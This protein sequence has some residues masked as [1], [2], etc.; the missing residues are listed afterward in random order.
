MATDQ[1]I[2]PKTRDFVDDDEG[3]WEEVEDSTTAVLVQLDSR[4]GAWWGDPRAGSRNAEILESEVPT[5]GALQDSSRRALQAMAGAGIISNVS[6]AITD[7][8]TANGIAALEV[9]WRDRSTNRP[10]DLAYSPLG[11][12]PQIP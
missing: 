3:G 4:E 11:G 5:I 10:A 7:E 6:V 2:D 12:A 9:R 8:D 1:Y